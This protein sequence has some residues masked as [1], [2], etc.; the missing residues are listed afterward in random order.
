MNR[1]YNS[2]P[3]DLKNLFSAMFILGRADELPHEAIFLNFLRKC[4]S[5]LGQTQWEKN[6]LR[7]L[8]GFLP[9]ER[10]YTCRGTE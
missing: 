4:Q 1:A 7:S 10:C 3:R 5:P 2:D 8:V 9:R 6:S